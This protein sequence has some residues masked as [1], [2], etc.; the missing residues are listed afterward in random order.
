MAARRPLAVIGALVVA[1]LLPSAAARAVSTGP[2][3]PATKFPRSYG[4]SAGT[5]L[6]LCLDGPPFCFGA[7]ADM[8]APDG[9]AFYLLASADFTTA[10]GPGLWEAGVE[11][12]YAGDGNDQEST[13]QRIRM[14]INVPQVGTYTV[15]HP[16]GQKT[17]NVTSV[18]PAF[19]IN[20]TLDAG[21]FSSPPVNTCNDGVAPEFSDTTLG[22]LTTFLRWD[23]AVAPAAPAGFIGDNA[24]EHA[25]IGSPFG[26]NFL[27]IDGPNIGGPGTNVFQINGFVVQGK[28]SPGM[29]ATPSALSFGPATVGTATVGPSPGAKSVTVANTLATDVNLTSVTLAGAQPADFTIQP[30]GTCGA[31]VTA[32]SSC[33]IS[34]AFAPTPSS[35]GLRSAQLRVV[36]DA[37]G[38]PLT[39]ALSGTGLPLAPPAPTASPGQGALAVP[40]SVTLSDADTSAVV[41]VTTNGSPASA[42]SPTYAG[43]IPVGVGTT[44]IR[45]VAVDLLGHASPEATFT[46]T[47]LS[48]LQLTPAS[49]DLG[50]VGL[51]FPTASRTYTLKNDGA[52]PVNVVGLTVAGTNFADFAITGG[53]CVVGSLAA[54][55]SC[56][57]NLVFTPTG[58]GARDAALLVASDAPG[59][60]HTAALHGTGLAPSISAALTSTALDFGGQR[61]GNVSD[62]LQVTMSNTGTATMHMASPSITG[63]DSRHFAL[64][65]STCGN[66]PPGGSCS[67]T[68]RFE[69]HARGAFSAAL[70]LD[71]DAAGSPHTVVLTGRG[72]PPG[73]YLLGQDGGIFAL[74]DAP[75]KG[76][77]AAVATSTNAVAMATTP[78]GRGYWIA[79]RDG[80]VYPF[81]DAADFGSMGGL[82]LNKPIVGMTSAHDGN[83][84]WLVAEDGGIFAFGPSAKFW[85][86]TG[87]IALNKPIVG[88]TTAPDGNGYWMVAGDGGVFAFGPGAVF[89]GS[90]ARNGVTRPVVDMEVT[91][92][93]DGYWMVGEDG[94][95]YAFG[96]ARNLGSLAGTRLNKPIAAMM[97]TEGG[98]GYWLVAQ[99]GGVFSFGDALFAGSVG[100]LTLAR[101]VVGGAAIH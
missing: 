82:R 19:E 13:F 97:S 28:L 9:E 56:S 46:Y 17:F 92:S 78:S 47:I 50:S 30:G 60:P 68:V 58:I 23:P 20:D 5:N 11:A 29:S 42:A 10:G 54:G 84:Y 65:R 8:V 61:V 77:A 90:A 6:D 81:G 73:Y 44:T 16:Y 48:P 26:T 86:S 38:S 100:R 4:D 27:R 14:R 7:A 59:A 33:T 89:H 94:N 57:V 41:H 76:S 62:P 51:S 64:A 2:I 55:Q 99:D 35:L 79:T 45:A 3:D 71:S 18:G 37:T 34:V 72:S 1:A 12:A 74:G 66:I 87:S 95:V 49:Q 63:G 85:G 43:P 15:T 75:F 69:P 21:C 80:N 40:Q 83:G 36:H 22:P 53:T 98:N 67:V 52:T 96:D 93:G 32:G 88:M 101:P 70:R 91:P 25:V 31:V 39:V 24:S